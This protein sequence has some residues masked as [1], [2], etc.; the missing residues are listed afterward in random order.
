LRVRNTAVLAKR[1]GCCFPASAEPG[2]RSPPNYSQA[3]WS[4]ALPGRSPLPL[5]SKSI[6]ETEKNRHRIFAAAEDSG[7]ILFFD[8]ADERASVSARAGTVN[9]LAGAGF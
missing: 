1:S 2:R 6:G 4:A 3:I 7:A 9:I 8:E 5:V